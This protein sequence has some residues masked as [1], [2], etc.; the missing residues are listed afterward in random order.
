HEVRLPG[1][2]VRPDELREPEIA[3]EIERVGPEAAEAANAALAAAF[4]APAEIFARLNDALERVPGVRLYVGRVG[5]EV[6]STAVGCTLDGAVGLFNV[7]TEEAHRRRGY[8]A[9]LTARAVRDGFAAGAELGYLQSSKAGHG[10]YRA[11]GFRDV[12]EYVLL[13][14][15]LPAPTG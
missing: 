8:G 7:A 15:P 5:G 12:E 4:S 11:L 1:M 2:V 10:V 13:G 9:V 6:A 14:R 3:V